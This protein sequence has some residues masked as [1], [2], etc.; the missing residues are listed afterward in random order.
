MI[1]LNNT[2]KNAFCHNSD[3]V[4]TYGEIWLGIGVTIGEFTTIQNN[5]WID[6]NTRIGAFN[7][8]C[9]GTRIG[10]NCFCGQHLSICNDRNPKSNN[11]DFA[12]E[13]VI[14]EDDVSIGSQVVLLPGIILGKG[15]KIGAGSCV[16]KSVPAG[17]IWVGNPAR[18]L[19]K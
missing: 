5:V 7:F 19:E 11:K 12:L 6:K 1:L 14:I 3:L 4:N 9:S 13:P 2:T 18:K 10:K 8:I 16:T 17:E 15:C